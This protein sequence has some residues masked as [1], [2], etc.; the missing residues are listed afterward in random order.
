MEKCSF[1]G[2]EIN[3]CARLVKS[4]VNKNVYICNTCADIVENR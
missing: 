3:Q 4:P 1:C 2:K